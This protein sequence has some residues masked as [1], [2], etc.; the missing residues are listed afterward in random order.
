M[1]PTPQARR[2]TDVLTDVQ[3]SPRPDTQQPPGEP[4]QDLTGTLWPHVVSAAIVA[5]AVAGLGGYLIGST[6][7]E[8]R[9]I[10]I[11]ANAAC[12]EGMTAADRA[13]AARDRADEHA[14]P[15]AQREVDLY[16]QILSGYDLGIDQ[17][18][19]DLEAARMHQ[20]RDVTSAQNARTDYRA[21]SLL[22][23]PDVVDVP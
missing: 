23:P 1:E 6:T 20:D 14:T 9:T 12:I 4:A 11:N 17:A 7:V 16:G 22:C 19:R 8:P 3:P 21:A 15:V 10:T 13:L 18:R 2:L 5:T